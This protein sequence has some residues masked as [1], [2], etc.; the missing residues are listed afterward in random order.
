MSVLSFDNITQTNAATTS[1]SYT[2]AGNNRILV[3]SLL[4]GSG[5]AGSVTYNGVSMTLQGS[6]Q[7][8]GAQADWIHTFSLINPALGT[9]TISIT[10]TSLLSSAAISY[11]N[12][13]QIKNPYVA[14]PSTQTT[15][16]PVTAS[17]T[18]NNPDCWVLLILGNNSGS[19]TGYSN[20]TA[21]GSSLNNGLD[22]AD[23]NGAVTPGSFSQTATVGAGTNQWSVL[24]LAIY[25]GITSNRT[26]IRPHAFSPGLAR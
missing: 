23:S 20:A 18:V 21:R 22:I 16:G 11:N 26:N 8:G 1:W 2:T 12:A 3:V 17:V 14:T 15:A 4:A 13:Y 6:P 24:Q 10:Q 19:P 5:T 25:A 9:N 7:F